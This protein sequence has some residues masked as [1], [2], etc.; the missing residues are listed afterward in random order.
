[1]NN[2][3]KSTKHV[4]EPLKEARLSLQSGI[5]IFLLS[6]FRKARGGLSS[7]GSLIQMTRLS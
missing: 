7:S 3:K 4:T 1:M 6:I 2:A 5:C